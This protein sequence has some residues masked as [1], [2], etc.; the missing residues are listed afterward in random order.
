MKRIAAIVVLCIAGAVAAGVALG[1]GT[2]HG[3]GGPVRHGKVIH[4]I[5]HATTDAVTNTG[6]GGGT[7]N[8]G[9]ILT[10]AN[11]VFD[12]KN[13][14]QVGSDQG[15]CIREVVG[16]SWE[17]N[18]TTFVPGGQVTVEGPFYDT[19]NSQ[20]AVTGGTGAYSHARGWMQ[21]NSLGG[22]T[23]YDFIFHLTP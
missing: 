11:P 6:N 9:D 5:E 1:A 7:D 10:F 21:L 16:Q 2:K 15:Y 13:S 23:Q 4:V 19:K 14:T 12:S 3:H 20:L 18:W 22:G 8:A 17:C